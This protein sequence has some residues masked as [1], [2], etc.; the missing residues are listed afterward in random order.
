MDETGVYGWAEGRGSGVSRLVI[1][2]YEGKGRGT[3][4]HGD[5]IL[6]LLVSWIGLL[7]PTDSPRKQTVSVLQ[8][9]NLFRDRVWRKLERGQVEWRCRGQGSGCG[10]KGK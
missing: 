10:R 7:I 8:I 1:V 6:L 3:L 5:L 9:W 2:S 4:F